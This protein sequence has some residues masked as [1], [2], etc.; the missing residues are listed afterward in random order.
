MK[1][2]LHPFAGLLP[3]RAG[4]WRQ[5]PPCPTPQTPGLLRRGERRWQGEEHTHN[6]KDCARCKAAVKRTARLTV[7]SALAQGSPALNQAFWR[8]RELLH[9]TNK[10]YF[11]SPT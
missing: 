6:S 5:H 7:N 3:G 11:L 2:P 1:A 9:R 4:G 8:L 10:E